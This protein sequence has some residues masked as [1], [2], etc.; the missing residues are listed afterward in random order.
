MNVLE[1]LHTHELNIMLRGGET[2]TYG[3]A[4]VYA[5]CGKEFDSLLH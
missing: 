5:A 2:G 1:L 4:M 3:A